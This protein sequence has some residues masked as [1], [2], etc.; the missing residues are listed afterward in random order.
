[1]AAYWN[2]RLVRHEVTG[3]VFASISDG[4]VDLRFP[5]NP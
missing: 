3:A 5:A 2:Y 4:R 1:M